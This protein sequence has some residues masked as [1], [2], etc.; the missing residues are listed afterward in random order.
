VQAGW[1][2]DADRMLGG[3]NKQLPDDR[4]VKIAPQGGVVWVFKVSDALAAK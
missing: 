3:I 1:G 2:V 4:Q